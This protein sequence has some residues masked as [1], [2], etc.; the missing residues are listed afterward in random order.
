[1]QHSSSQ[2]GGGHGAGTGGAGQKVALALQMTLEEAPN[3][4]DDN[5]LINA[6]E[7][8]QPEVYLQLNSQ[9]EEEKHVSPST[10]TKQV[11]PKKNTPQ[12]VYKRV[13]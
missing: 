11:S 10:K 2:K 8:A 4:A 9:K 12:S 6:T 7:I 3:E 5:N 1:M 13:S